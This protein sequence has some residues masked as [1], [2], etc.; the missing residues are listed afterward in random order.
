M[1]GSK[2]IENAL[3]ITPCISNKMEDAINLWGK[4]YKNE[5]PWLKVPNK[6]NAERVTSLGLPAMIVSEKARTALLEFK[7]EI[8]TPT[9]EVET[10]NPN[11]TEPEP[12]A[13]GNVLPSTEP[14]TIT[15]DV[16][17]SD[18]SRAEFLEKQYKKLKKKLRTQIEYGIA[19]GGLV[20]KPYLVSN[21]NTVANADGTEEE[22]TE[23]EIEF[24][25]IQADCFYPLA[26]DS[27]G[28]I[29][30]AAFLQS[31]VQKDKIYYRLEVHKW[32]GNKVTI[33]NK[34]Y[35]NNNIDSNPIDV[36][37]VSLG[38][39]IK[40]S[41]VPEWS[42]L[43][44]EITLNNVSKP[45]FAYFK[46]P[47]ANTVDVSSPLGVSGFDR[48]KSLIKDA[49]EQYSRLLWEYEGGEMAVDIDRD[50]LQF[51]QDPSGNGGHSELPRKQ[52]RLYRTV[53]L[54]ESNTYN[55]Y[56]PA[57]RDSSYM[58]G[59]NTILMRIEDVTSL[60]RGTL[61]D[62]SAEARTAT[63]LK[64]LKQRSYQANA[65]IQKAIEDCLEDVIYA[66]NVYATL[67]EVTPEGEYDVSYEWDDSIITDV[68][69]ELGHRI[70]LQNE[71]LASRLENRMW[72]FG[73][74]ERQ[75]QEALQKIDSEGM[76]NMENE[77]MM[78]SNLQRQRFGEE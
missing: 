68:N 14:K 5:A 59:L 19:K 76:A 55:I 22:Q 63:E 3:K 50:A 52:Q 61:S 39:E 48:A 54:G 72:Y 2:T 71:K 34:A 28:R 27:S 77:L 53:D 38:K 69:D 29:T 16:P 18:T 15:Q 43:E 13:F 7:S 62:A 65:D 12:D 35:V 42:G 66:M 26:F 57:L 20:I 11:Y 64:I 25:F 73:E 37:Q 31:K 9:E 40:L 4:M 70:T 24:D 1:F 32:E 56:A 75:A 46:M 36:T 17:T 33:S 8:T 67:Y 6:E 47:E 49:D 51:L 41:D 10:E 60:S 78:Q 30:E 58:Q 74:T 21:K 23:Y 45:L 44:E